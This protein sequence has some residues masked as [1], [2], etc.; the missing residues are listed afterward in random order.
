MIST[1]VIVCLLFYIEHY[2]IVLCTFHSLLISQLFS[3]RSVSFHWHYSSMHQMPIWSVSC[4]L[5]FLL[6]PSEWIFYRKGPL[7]WIM[8][9]FDWLYDYLHFKLS[10]IKIRSGTFKQALASWIQ[11]FSRIEHRII[12][13]FLFHLYKAVWFTSPKSLIS[14]QRMRPFNT[15]SNR[16]S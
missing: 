10:T 8:V 15:A 11:H 6:L 9:N 2:H 3:F 7:F 4:Q 16:S 13:T 5:C 12:N 1:C 14:I